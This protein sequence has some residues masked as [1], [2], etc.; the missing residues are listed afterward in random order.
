MSWIHIVVLA[1]VQGLT[2]I[3]PVSSSGHLVLVPNVMDWKDQGLVFDVAVHFG[4]LVA[5][6]LYFREDL[7]R[8]VQGAFRVLGGDTRSRES[9]LAL[10]IAL[11]TIPAAIAGLLFAG[12]IAENLRDPKVVVVTLSGYAVLLALADWFGKRRRE[13]A[14]LGIGGALLIGMAQALALI[15]GTSRS[16]VTI[17][18]GMALGLKRREAAR[19]SFLLSV[20]VILLAAL[21]ETAQVFM[22]GATATFGTLAMG[23][24]ISCVVAY[25]TINF[26]MRVIN[27]IGLVPFAVYRILL[28]AVILLVVV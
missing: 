2:E 17:T 1:V 27:S 10:C 11:G 23:A 26:F 16:G 15:P 13:M 25:L 5:I 7:L 9:Q 6:C 22:E 28:A 24:L 3:L 20:P 8:T 18:A 12:W 14:D 21:Y 19:F 4:T